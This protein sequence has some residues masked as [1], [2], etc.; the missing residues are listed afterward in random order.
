MSVT[1]STLQ[2]DFAAKFARI[3]DVR[4]EFDGEVAGGVPPTSSKL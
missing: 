3:V 2:P 1:L 4:R